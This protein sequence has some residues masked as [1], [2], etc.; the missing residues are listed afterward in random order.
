[1]KKRWLVILLTIGMVL[2]LLPTAAW[3]EG[4]TGTV[5]DEIETPAAATEVSTAKEL[6]AAVSASGSGN[7]VR[8]KNNIQVSGYLDID[9]SVTLDLNDYTLSATGIRIGYNASSNVEFAAKGGTIDVPVN[10]T[11][12][13][14]I[15]GGT[16]SGT[17]NNNNVI[18]GG[19]FHGKVGNC[20]LVGFG[21]IE[22][23]EARITGGDFYGEVTNGSAS[24]GNYS[25]TIIGGNFYGKVTNTGFSMITGGDFYDGVVSNARRYL[26]KGIPYGCI[27]GGTFYDGL[28]DNSTGEG[29]VQTWTV[30][31]YDGINTEP[32]AIQVVQTN[33]TASAP[34]F[35][36]GR[37]VSGWYTDEACTEE[38]D[39]SSSVTNNITLYAKLLLSYNLTITDKDGT[40]HNVTI[41]NAK[42]VLGDG[43]HAVVYTP[44]YIDSNKEFT[45]DDWDKALRGETVEGIRLPKLTL[46]GANLRQIDMKGAYG[47]DSSM[48]LLST[49]LQ[50][51]LVGD[52]KINCSGNNCY[53]VGVHQLIISG[54]GSLSVTATGEASKA[55]AIGWD[56]G[57]RQNGGTVTLSDSAY[58]IYS[59]AKFE[60]T[61]GK[62]T[63]SSS[64]YALH[65]GEDE[66]RVSNPTTFYCGGSEKTKFEIKA[67]FDQ[68]NISDQVVGAVKDGKLQ[69][70]EYG[71]IILYA[72]LTSNYTVTFDTDGGSAIDAQKVAYGGKATAPEA[73]TRSGYTFAGWYLGDTKYTFD[74]PVTKNITLIAHWTRNS[75]GG[76]GG[77]TY[78][79]L[80]FDTNGGSALSALRLAR[81][82]TVDLA[83]Y[84][85]ERSGHVFTG[86]YADAALTQPIE[87]LT[88]SASTTV[89]A[90]WRAETGDLPFTDVGADAWY[91]DDV[92]YV[93]DKG[94]M[95]GTTADRFAPNGS[96]TR[97]MLVTVLWRQAGSPVVNYAMDFSDVAEGAWYAE[98]VRWAAAEGVVGGYGD[99]R[100]GPDDPITRE[101]LATI[102]FRHLVGDGAAELADWLRPYADADQIGAYAVPA[103]QWAVGHGVLKGDGDRLDP[104]GTATRAQ[105]AA[106]LHR[107]LEL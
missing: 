101:Q 41:E 55:V 19:T 6:T 26:W 63:V 72:Q 17:V 25:G 87:T 61:A 11:A 21:Q 51:E 52:N 18:S 104:Q 69:E 42:D 80:T 96:M 15:R 67:P 1:M 95:T 16:F 53:A 7:T 23:A 39:F 24:E 12:A 74:T 8:L 60:F 48:L 83:R 79:T 89:Y 5:N 86:W 65:C 100:F 102:L 35:T 84:V 36:D 4:E 44:G 93:Y 33:G 46:N 3:A 50:L 70:S 75:S 57:Y 38:Y 94:L 49:M 32:C 85:P 71:P 99:G 105:V 98:A 40:R 31:Y 10:N 90:G 45:T 54:E 27:T 81:G 103:M 88:L 29:P 64:K 13:G 20:N 73:P 43:S 78:Y 14:I 22:F 77:T 92:Q 9:R 106:V 76:G 82:S 30:T 2:T 107:A 47:S 91:R 34:T 59:G 37:T 56:G 28:T 66:F 97:A 68:K 58:G 62:L